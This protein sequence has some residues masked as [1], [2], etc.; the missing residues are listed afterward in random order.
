MGKKNRMLAPLAAA[1]LLLGACEDSTGSRGAR[2][3][4][5]LT[6]A[7][8]GLAEAWV[9]VEQIYLQGSGGRTVLRD[10][11]TGLIDLLTLRNDVAALVDSAAVPAGS[12]TELRFVIGDAYV[13]TADGRVF[14]RPGTQLPAGTTSAGTLQ[15]PS[16]AQS[17]IKVK[18]ANGGVTLAEESKVVV[19]FDVSQ[20][21][22]HQAGQSGR[23]V[24]RPVLTGAEMAT[25]GSIAGTVALA[26][27]VTLPATC[28]GADVSLA[29]FIPR[30]LIGADTLA[31]GS[32]DASGAYR[33]RYLA[34]GSYTLGHATVTYDGG[35]TLAFTAAATPASVTVAS[36]ATATADY[37]ISAA[38]CQ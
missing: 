15:C 6:D 11:S 8:G 21:F 4:I 10:E 5:H 32:T 37:T 24:M 26:E 16:C 20:S 35:Q 22:G 33:I 38:T 9:E 1:A 12:Y 2:L 23:W 31:S 19:D 7:P 14:A 34:P 18:F 25:A 28:G 17:G 30:A 36:G 3:S 27:G 13:R 29:S